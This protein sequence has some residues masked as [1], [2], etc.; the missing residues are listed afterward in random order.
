[1]PTWQALAQ[2]S[3]RVVGGGICIV[4]LI[5]TQ[6]TS[7]STT[8]HLPHQALAGRHLLRRCLLSSA[9]KHLL[10]L[11]CVWYLTSSSSPSATSSSVSSL[12]R[13]VSSSKS[14]SLQPPPARQEEASAEAAAASHSAA[15]CRAA[16]R[17]TT[18]SKS[19]P[20]QATHSQTHSA[21]SRLLAAHPR[22]LCCQLMLV[23]TWRTAG[24][25]QFKPGDPPLRHTLPS[26]HQHTPAVAASA[27]S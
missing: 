18:Q 16:V 21:L 22:S 15:S 2:D 4:L 23:Q 19:K 27:R 12:R 3:V 17:H 26:L 11:A 10:N 13:R 14:D 9:P 1:M 20:G 6:G 8:Q 25:H 5:A 7:K 24:L